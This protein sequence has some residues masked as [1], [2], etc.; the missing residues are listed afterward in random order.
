MLK[1]KYDVKSRNIDND[2]TSTVYFVYSCHYSKL[3]EIIH[4]IDRDT[5]MLNYNSHAFNF[6]IGLHIKLPLFLMLGRYITC[7]N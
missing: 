6:Q 3:L 4:D 1:I 5:W 2:M 7:L